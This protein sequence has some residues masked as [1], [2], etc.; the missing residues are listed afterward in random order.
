MKKQH[1]TFTRTRHD[2]VD[3]AVQMILSAIRCAEHGKVL[4]SLS[5]G[6]TPFP[7]YEKLAELLKKESLTKQLF[8]IQTDERNV[9]NGSPRLNQLAIK[10]SLFSAK[11]LSADLFYPIRTRSHDYEKSSEMC[12]KGLPQDL[13]PPRPIDLLILGMGAD[14]HTASLFPETDWRT[15]K[16]VSGYA[17]FKPASQPE[18]RISLTLDRILAAKKIIFLISGKD[19]AEALKKVLVE[20]SAEVPA[21]MVASKKECFWIFSPEVLESCPDLIKIEAHDSNN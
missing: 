7:V 9:E 16:S 14:G 17:L 21:G 10:N 13:L 15:R 6:K 11:G 3:S 5:G 4:I 8:F 1:L 20:G 18:S 2:F 19:K 12:C